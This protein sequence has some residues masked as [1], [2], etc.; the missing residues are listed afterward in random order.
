MKK[1][2]L[3]LGTKLII[4]FLG[5]GLVP[6]V[7]A[8]AA[9]LNNISVSSKKA[10]GALKSEADTLISRIERNLFERYGDVQAFGLQEAFYDTK[11]WS[12]VGGKAKLVKTMNRYLATYTPIYE[13][14]LLIDLKGDLVAVTNVDHEGKPVDTSVFGT[15]NY[16]NQTWF[17]NAKSGK[18][19]SGEAITGTWVD[20]VHY[21]KDFQSVFSGN[22]LLIGFAAPVKD[23]SGKLIGVYR[24]YARLEPIENIIQEGYKELQD[25]GLHRPTITVIDR[26]GK[27]I[28]EYAPWKSNKK[29]IV[30]DSSKTLKEDWSS[31]PFV[32][33]AM[34][35]KSGSGEARDKVVGYVK[36]AGALGY[37]G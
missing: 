29:E 6:L 31:H 7:L 32:K 36:S 4:A 21:D 19:L 10:E 33:L 8:A 26:S 13:M 15:K 30:Y 24:N 27:L 9:A 14:S 17:K 12:T 1:K 18:F 20:P 11:T 25:S 37:P 3:K 22:G 28:L 2:G 23:A 5:F 34:A 16:S 35:G